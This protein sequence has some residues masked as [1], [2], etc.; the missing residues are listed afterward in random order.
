MEK[1][2]ILGKLVILSYCIILFATGDT[3][4]TTV[5]VLSML[6]YICL[7]MAVYIVKE[8]RG[9]KVLLILSAALLLGCFHYINVLFILLLPLNLYELSFL[10]SESFW[11]P[12]AL[13]AA[14]L[15]LLTGESRA[16][17]L[18]AGALGYIIYILSF[19]AQ[20]RLRALALENDQLREKVYSLSGRLNRDADFQHQVKYSSQLEERNKI[21]QEIHDRVGHAIAGS[22]MQ[23]EAAR[24][25][26]D[27]DSGRS[28]KIIQHVIN[29]LREGMESIRA[30]LSNIK[31]PAGQ[32]GINRLKLLL[33]E[34]ANSHR[35][36]TALLHKGNLERISP[37]QWKVILDNAGEA[38]TNVLKYSG[39][40]SVTV[41]IEVL[42]KIIKAEVKDN[43][44]GAYAVKKGLGIKGMEE[45]SAN[46]GGK[47]IIDGSSGFSAITLLPLDM[48]EDA[49]NDQAADS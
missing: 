33:D 30:T 34:F 7:N 25:L 28:E 47:V 31:P 29:T 45:R 2:S 40:T 42:H 15:L 6:A 11:W 16:E 3:G 48:E 32:L 49:G 17:Y 18:L 39:A 20:R 36:N 37:V 26:M 10:F 19:K 8:I 24:L 21:A 14:P 5:F 38:L 23:L 44:L 41:N 22:L 46:I 35:V 27:K 9:Q 13:A 1:W 12:V 4:N 43:G